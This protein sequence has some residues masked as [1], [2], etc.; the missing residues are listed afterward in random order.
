M[1]L[2]QSLHQLDQEISLAPAEDL[3]RF[4]QMLY[5]GKLISLAFTDWVFGGPE[6]R[7]GQVRNQEWSTTKTETSAW[8]EERQ[9]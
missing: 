2:D 1:N 6:P 9:E 5:E 8:L 7:P 4:I 3:P